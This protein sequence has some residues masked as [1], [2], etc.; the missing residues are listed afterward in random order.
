MRKRDSR[1]PIDESGYAHK[2]NLAFI[3]A[4]LFY[5][6]LPM[7]SSHAFA[8]NPTTVAR[9]AEPTEL[10]RLADALREENLRSAPDETERQELLRV[11]AQTMRTL[12]AADD[13]ELARVARTLHDELGQNVAAMLLGLKT[14]GAGAELSPRCLPTLR[15]LGTLGQHMGQ[16]I[17]RLAVAMRPLAR[18]ERGLI[19]ALTA[20]FEEWSS[21]TGIG[22]SFQPPDAA[23]ARVVPLAETCLYQIIR[24]LLHELAAEAEPPGIAVDLRIDDNA[25][26]V[27]IDAPGRRPAET[28]NLASARARAALLAGEVSVARPDDETT[29]YTVRLPL[30]NLND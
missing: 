6:S 8:P 5:E 7:S 28:V 30:P 4:W 26:E 17:H 1:F 13:A 15:L 11:R 18:L 25:I 3:C 23:A 29:R 27:R 19:P 20:L 2:E 22:V 9:D 12:L 14:L 24:D 10:E 16:E 21:A